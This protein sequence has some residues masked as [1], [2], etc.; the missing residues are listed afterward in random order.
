MR[1]VIR[2]QIMSSCW[3][4]DPNQRPSF[5][6]LANRLRRE[7]PT[8]AEEIGGYDSTYGSAVRSVL[9]TSS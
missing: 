5:S 1:S 6:E 2:Y 3:S 4:L 8:G 9:Q 7:L